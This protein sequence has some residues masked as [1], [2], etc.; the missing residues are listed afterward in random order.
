V[1]HLKLSSQTLFDAAAPAQ[2]EAYYTLWRF[3]PK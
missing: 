1:Y 2:M 3:A